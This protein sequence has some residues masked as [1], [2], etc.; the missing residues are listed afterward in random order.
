ML[1]LIGVELSVF[2]GDCLCLVGCNGF[3]K[4][5]FLKIVVGMIE[6]DCGERFF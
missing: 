4:L 6:M 2:E 5:M 3:G 1:F